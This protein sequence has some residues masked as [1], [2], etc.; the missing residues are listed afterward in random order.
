MLVLGEIGNNFGAGMTGGV[1]YLLASQFVKAN[2]NSGSVKIVRPSPEHVDHALHLLK[3]H[4]ALTGS[5]WAASLLADAD[6]TAADLVEVI[7]RTPGVVK[8]PEPEFMDEGAS[9]AVAGR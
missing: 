5:S 3:Q 2:V 9:D 1:A 7:P 6:L 4:F 8:Q